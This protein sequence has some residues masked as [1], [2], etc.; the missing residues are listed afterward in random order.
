MWWK[1]L[2]RAWIDAADMGRHFYHFTTI[3]IW[4]RL[5]FESARSG[6]ESEKWRWILFFETI[7]LFLY[8][9]LRLFEVGVGAFSFSWISF[10]YQIIK[11]CLSLIL[12]FSFLL[13]L[14]I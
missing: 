14:F 4:E 1:K 11:C 10:G 6:N 7:S 5:E 13:S 9:K 8:C 12:L 3:I 2:E